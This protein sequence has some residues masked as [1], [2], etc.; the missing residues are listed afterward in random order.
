M[1][2]LT[3]VLIPDSGNDIAMIYFV[4]Y[5]KSKLYLSSIYLLLYCEYRWYF[6][7]SYEDAI[8]EWRRFT[9][10]KHFADYNYVMEII[11]ANGLFIL[12]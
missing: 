7:L 5:V 2:F 1:E 4:I 8:L 11:F 10:R 3:I 9:L 6:F 12:N